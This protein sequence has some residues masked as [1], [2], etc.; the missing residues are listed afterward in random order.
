MKIRN[1]V[2]GKIIF[3]FKMYLENESENLAHVLIKKTEVR[4][5]MQVYLQLI[6]DLKIVMHPYT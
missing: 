6:A 2:L 5:L 4:I 3:T 1:L